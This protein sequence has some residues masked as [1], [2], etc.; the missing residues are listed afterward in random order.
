LSYPRKR[1][2]A[3]ALADKPQ[4]RAIGFFCTFVPMPVMIGKKGREGNRGR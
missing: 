4:L 2:K 3:L 1:E